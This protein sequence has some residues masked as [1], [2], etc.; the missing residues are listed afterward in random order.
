MRG[1]EGRFRC[2]K[3]SVTQ[4]HSEESKS[5]LHDSAK[6]CGHLGVS[7]STIS[8]QP[9]QGA[10]FQ[11]VQMGHRC[12]TKDLKVSSNLFP[13]IMLKKA[14][15]V[16]TTAPT[17][18]GSISFSEPDQGARFQMGQMGH[19][20]FGPSLIEAAHFGAHKSFPVSW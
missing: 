6:P 2:A 12:T 16:C 18:V 10:G 8:S 17:L 4:H 13:N 3:K 5:I 1:K 20:Q 19:R 11:M 15:V 14:K 9:D 7:P